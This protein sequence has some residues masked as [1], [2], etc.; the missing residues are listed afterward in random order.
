M[1][2]IPYK[3]YRLS[4]D[5]LNGEDNLF[6]VN[7][8][9]IRGITIGGIQDSYRFFS[10]DVCDDVNEVI[11]LEVKNDGE[12]YYFKPLCSDD[13]ILILGED[14][15]Y[16]DSEELNL[17][18]IRTCNNRIDAY[19]S[20]MIRDFGKADGDVFDKRELVTENPLGVYLASIQ[21]LS[22]IPYNGESMVNYNKKY[23][24]DLEHKIARMKL[25]AQND[26]IEAY[27]RIDKKSKRYS[28]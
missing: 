7:T 25:F 18:E 26:I 5:I 3:E 12:R 22:S 8:E 27:A 11:V 15:Y 14:Y 19:K 9:D 4:H 28:R 13:Y 10:Y 1:G 20:F 24:S 16:G 6:V 23:A 21:S 17:G 2:V